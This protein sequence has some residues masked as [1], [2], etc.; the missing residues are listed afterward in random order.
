[1]RAR[2]HT[3]R[4]LT[5]WQE[6][7][8]DR[9]DW[10]NARAGRWI[11]YHNIAL[12]ASK[13]LAWLRAANARHHDIYVR[14]AR[15]HRWPHL[16]LDDLPIATARTL[17]QR[18]RSVIV[19]TSPR[20]GCHLHLITNRPV[21]EIERHRLQQ[22]LAHQHGADLAATA[23]AQFQRLPG[24]RNWKR[25]GTWVNI[26][27]QSP[28]GAPPLPVEEHLPQEDRNTVP[29]RQ[30]RTTVNIGNATNHSRVDHSPSGKDWAYVCQR[31]E[32][33]HPPDDIIAD[34]AH[35]VAHR[36]ESRAQAYAAYTVTKALTTI[37]RSHT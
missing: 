29:T 16:F 10:A 15:H 23:G 37:Y 20:G 17:A 21:T 11:N 19:H 2:D 27:A 12:P 36:H 25:H 14:P 24:M 9:V 3:N 30:P 35:R 28:V 33:R 31:L 22:H 34:L 26:I 13:H 4:L 32:R 6:N 5:W 7:G 8:I 1:M 18:Y